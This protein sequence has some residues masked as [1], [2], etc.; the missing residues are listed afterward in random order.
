MINKILYFYVLLSVLA[1]LFLYN[2]YT[3]YRAR[4]ETANHNIE[5][6]N[7]VADNIKDYTKKEFERYEKALSDTLNKKRVT[8]VH[9]FYITNNYRDTTIVEFSPVVGDTTKSEFNEVIGC[10]KVGGVVSWSD[11]ELKITAIDYD[12]KVVV[13]EYLGRREKKK[14]L[15]INFR[16]GKR[17]RKLMVQSACGDSLEVEKINIIDE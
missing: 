2:G 5:A 13:A 8:E 16:I 9:K 10:F 6:F 12:N 17:E 3:T 11:K 4:Y 15:F 14:I 7:G 1:L